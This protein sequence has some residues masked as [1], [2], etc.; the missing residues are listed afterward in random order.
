MRSDAPPVGRHYEGDLGA[1]Y[2][3]RADYGELAARIELPRFEQHVSESDVVVDFGCNDGHLLELLPGRRKIGVEPNDV[4]RQAGEARGLTILPSANEIPDG[5]VDVA[6]AQHSLEHALAPWHELC[7]LH[8]ILKPSGR[9]VLLLPIDD[10]RKQRRPRPDHDHH[11]YTWTPQLLANLLSEAGFEVRDCHV[12][13][14]AWPPFSEVLFRRLP[15]RGFD[16]LAWG[17]SV[18]TRQR[19]VMAL[20]DRP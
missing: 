11:V 18:A 9:L 5:I 20:A 1:R 17:W 8:R 12:V 15:R 19:Q 3:D 2:Y 16:L 13:T 4:A 7:E 10:W 14:H 6:V